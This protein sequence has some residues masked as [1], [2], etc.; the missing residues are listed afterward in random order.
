MGYID[1]SSAVAQCLGT[2]LVQGLIPGT[3][4]NE[5]FWDTQIVISKRVGVLSP[6]PPERGLTVRFTG[7]QRQ[8]ALC[9]K[10][11]GSAAAEAS[12]ETESGESFSPSRMIVS[13][14]GLLL[15]LG[16]RS[17]LTQACFSDILHEPYLPFLFV[18]EEYVRKPPRS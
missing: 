7:H 12:E 5:G 11:E 17:P 13:S 10:R 16:R 4:K 3:P 2:C 1:F 6:E 18:D 14:A 8:A 9:G 15:L